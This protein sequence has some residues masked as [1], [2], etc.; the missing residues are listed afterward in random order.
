MGSLHRGPRSLGELRKDD[1]RAE[2]EHGWER[3]FE[4][5]LFSPLAASRG[6]RV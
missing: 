2:N 4:A 5:C 1:R 6:M 3:F